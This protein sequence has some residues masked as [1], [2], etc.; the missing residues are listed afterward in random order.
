MIKEFPYK[1]NYFFKFNNLKKIN[2]FV[3][4]NYKKP[5]FLYSLKVIKERYKLLRNSFPAKIKIY[6]AQKSNPS[7]NILTTLSSL[8][9]G[10]DTASI[11]EIKNALKAGFK[12]KDIMFSGPGK[13]IDEINFAVKNNINLINAESLQEL[14]FINS[15]CKNLN[16]KQKILLRVNPQFDLNEKNKIIGGKG[17]SKF[18]V[19]VNEIP[20]IIKYIQANQ[21][22]ILAGFHIFNSSQILNN[23]SIIKNCSKVIEMV[24]EICKKYKLNITHIDLGG[25]FGIPYSKNEKEINL[26]QI[27][28]GIQKILH[29]KKY[30][31]FLKNINLIFEPGRFISGMSGIYITKVL[32]TK[33]SYG[34]NILIT[35]GGINHLL[36]PALINQKHPILNLTAMMENRKKYL[37]YKI[38]GPLCT[39]IDEFDGNCKLRE[40]KQGDFLMILNSGAYGY[41]ESMLHFLSHPLPDEK[42]LS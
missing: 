25:G 12:P 28:N 21:N 37:N 3:I 18:G 1:E 6:Y 8:K 19:D 39:A 41:S 40:T 20:K 36:R 5:L 4:N 29:Q 2:D 24:F 16:K 11:G 32:Y 31:E 22:L 23:N 34:K 10:C 33:K 17:V 15:V 7:K 35:D 26:K 27:N 13:N 30:K 14:E 38:A 9:S 42:Y